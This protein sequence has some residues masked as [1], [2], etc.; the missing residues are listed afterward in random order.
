[1]A[2]W[3]NAVDS[4][5]IVLFTGYRGFKSLSLRQFNWKDARW[6]RLFLM[7]FF[8]GFKPVRCIKKPKASRRGMGGVTPQKRRWLRSFAFA[9]RCAS[10]HLSLVLEPTL[11]FQ[12]CQRH[13]KTK[14]LKK[15]LLV[16][17]RARRGS[18]PQ[19]SA[20]EADTLSNWA[21]GAHF[22][23][24]Y[25]LYTLL[26]QNASKIF[27]WAQNYK[28]YLQLERFLPNLGASL[29]AERWFYETDFNFGTLC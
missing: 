2:E 21:T 8:C 17:W 12:T 26:R 16:F 24:A 14:S 20:S 9:H 19:P 3:S 4:K 18:N 27:G 7:A 22:G 10:A 25:P 1:M 6:R 15:R 11:W 5:S 13:Q 28:N 23:Y 29:Q